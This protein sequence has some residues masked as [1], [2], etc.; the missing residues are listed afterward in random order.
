MPFIVAHAHSRRVH[1]LPRCEED[2][3]DDAKGSDP[4]ISASWWR[5]R[6]SRFAAIAPIGF[7][8]RVPTVVA[9]HRSDGHRFSKDPAAAVELIAGIGIEGDAHAGTLVQH[10][11]RV[12]ADPTQPNL[13][14]VHVIASELFTLLA[15]AGHPVGPGDLGENITTEGLDVHGLAVGSML[16]IGREALVAVTGL[17]N[18][19][20][21]I[22]RFQPGLLGHVAFRDDDG[23]LVRRAGI[24]GVVI[25][26]GQVVV[27]DDITVSP[28]PGPPRPLDRV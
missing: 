5:T 26:G 2:H 16:L 23:A 15:S 4:S 14:Q 22:E 1:R 11:S 13:R 3:E 18:P 24:M 20:V 25:R 10:R 7:A 21:Q 8:E 27:G 17:R 6:R 28:P 19:C 9:L 12:A